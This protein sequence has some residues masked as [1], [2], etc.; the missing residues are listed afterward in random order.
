MWC[1][2]LRGPLTQGYFGNKSVYILC[3]L[4]VCTS[5]WG[6]SG[7]SEEEAGSDP[8]ASTMENGSAGGGGGSSKT[9]C[10]AGDWPSTI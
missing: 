4:Y 5:G 9:G 3:R 6:P 10:G 1:L 8:G 2:V 7:P